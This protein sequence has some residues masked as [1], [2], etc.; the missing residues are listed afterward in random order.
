MGGGG[1]CEVPVGLLWIIHN[2]STARGSV[3]VVYVKEYVGEEG[4]KDC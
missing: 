1:A 2:L 3:E 4:V